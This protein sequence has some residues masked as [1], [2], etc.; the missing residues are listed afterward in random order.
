MKVLYVGG[1][2]NPFIKSGG[3]GDVLGALPKELVKNGVD[4]RVVIPKYKNINKE[5]NNK[6]KFIKWFMVK[7]GW[8][9]QYCGIFEYDYEGVKYY[10]LDNEYY[11]RREG[12]YGYVDDGE[13]FAFFTRAVLEFMKEI[14]YQP[15]VIHCNDWH[16]GMIPVLLKLEYSRHLFYCDMKTAFSIHNL[17]FQ[18]T[19][20]KNILTELFGYD[21]EP[22]YNGSL[23][24]DDGISFMKGGIMY[25]DIISTVSN[26]Y[27]DEIKSVEYGER[28]DSILNERAY[29]LHGILNGID[30]DEY[31]PE[32]DK[33]IY[34]QFN[35]NNYEQG[36]KENKINL[37][38]ELRIKVN[39]DIPIIGIVSRLTSQKGLDLIVS[40]IDRILQRDVQLII[41]GTGDHHFEEHF[42]NLQYRY[43]EKVSANIFFDDSLAHK[44]Y[45]SSDMFLMPSLFE[46]C[47]L[48]QLIALR[49]GSIPIVRETGG[50]KDTIS[51]FNKYTG[52]GN[53]FSFKNYNAYEMVNIIEEALDTFKNK[54]VWNSIIKQ[55]LDSNNSWEKSAKDY[56]KLYESF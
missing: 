39:E 19:F 13:R 40:M 38:K 54:D 2:A 28:M 15:D 17:K 45:A 30:Y 25:S 11:F 6:L 26:S 3:L 46:P 32:N 50:L 41:L 10:L 21:L 34:S 9:N 43:R 51:A 18:G 42:K 36:K 24:F 29:A 22:Y 49:Y 4:A 23:A 44:I 31:N 1:E 48:G 56:L 33:F 47:G 37:Q 5:L 35:R 55:A 53:G 8:R 16:T 27:V 7:V 12:M 14:D 52:K 20:D